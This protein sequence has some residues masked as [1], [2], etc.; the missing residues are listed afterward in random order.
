MNSNYCGRILQE[1]YSEALKNK[2]RE[3]IAACFSFDQIDIPIMPYISAWRVDQ[4]GIWYEY[5]S[6]QFLSLF[7]CGPE[8]IAQTFCKAILDRREY[9]NNGDTPFIQELILSREE[10]NSRNADPA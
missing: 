1:N 2:V 8:A 10:L 9:K 5:V 4:P 6:R 7:N 3:Q